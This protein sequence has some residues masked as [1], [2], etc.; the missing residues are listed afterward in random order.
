MDIWARVSI[1]T[2]SQYAH[3]CGQEDIAKLIDQKTEEL[4][5]L[6][7]H[8]NRGALEDLNESKAGNSAQKD[9]KG[10]TKKN[11]SSSSFGAFMYRIFTDLASLGELFGSTLVF[12][13]LSI[14]TFV[15]YVCSAT[16]KAPLYFFNKYHHIDKPPEQPKSERRSFLPQDGQ[17]DNAV[18]FEIDASHCMRIKS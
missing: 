10:P 5:L 14:G 18:D 8:F 1:M 2:P 6:K 16:L 7:S 17:D 11:N 3:L 15:G 4:N 12:I 13:G 9:T